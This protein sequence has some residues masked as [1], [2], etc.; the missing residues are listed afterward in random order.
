MV[1]ICL[2]DKPLT[3]DKNFLHVSGNIN[4]IIPSNIR[5]NAIPVTKSFQA[6]YR[7]PK[8]RN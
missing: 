8:K 7:H 4:G 5:S 1:R 3:L 6:K 2:S